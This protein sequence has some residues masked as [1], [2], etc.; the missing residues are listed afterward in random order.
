MADFEVRT[1]QLESMGDR[2]NA[3][4]KSVKNISNEA[5][6]VMASTRYSITAKLAAS[7]QRAVVCSS[8]NNCATDFS[9]LSKGIKRAAKLYSSAE[10]RILNGTTAMDEMVKKVIQIKDAIVAKFNEWKNKI[11]DWVNSI[12]NPQPSVY[13]VDSIVFDDDGAYG[14]NQSSPRYAT[15]ERR[16]ELYDTVRQYYPNMTD[17]QID[18]Y[19]VKLEDEGCGYVAVVNTIFAAYEGREEE[20][21]RAFGFSMYDENGDLNYDRLIVDYYAATDNHKKNFWGKDVINTK[22]D[23]GVTDGSG[24]NDSKRKYRTELYMEA[25]N[26]DVEIKNDVKVT[27]SNFDDYAD[28]Y[29]IVSYADG[30]LY[31]EDG[32]PATSRPIGGHAMVITG[33]TDD[34]RYIVSSWGEEY[35]L[36]PDEGNYRNFAYYKY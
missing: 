20:F 34:G 24:T 11:V 2:F 35:Y 8:I 12:I 25:R 9:A 15:G 6:S 10:H 5:R 1:N 18:D 7:L 29:I 21:E 23:A 14:G 13:K 26:V 3:I 19:L 36:K 30:Y 33:V 32:T 31:N 17:E 28:G 27:P 4:S 22:E 16:E